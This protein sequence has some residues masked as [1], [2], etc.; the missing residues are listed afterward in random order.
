MFAGT[1]RMRHA[2]AS[3]LRSIYKFYEENPE[4]ALALREEI[5]LIRAVEGDKMLIVVDE[6][7]HIKAAAAVFEHGTNGEHREAGATLVHP[8]LRGYKL[9]RPLL[10]IRFLGEEIIDPDFKTFFS[11]VRKSNVV[12]LFNLRSVG[13]IERTPDP[14]IR[15]FKNLEGRHYLHLPRWCRHQHASQILTLI[16]QP[17]LQRRNGDTMQLHLDVKIVMPVWRSVLRRYATVSPQ[18]VGNRPKWWWF[19][20]V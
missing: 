10:Q 16:K 20:H 1:Y 15:R 5:T 14:V 3:D 19:R 9:Q 13:F 18:I 4:D 7:D 17:H 8:Q 12:S 11:V 2:H 6:D